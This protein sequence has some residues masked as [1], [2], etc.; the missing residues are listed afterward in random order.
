MSQAEWK[1]RRANSVED[2]WVVGNRVKQT[3]RS[4]CQ[5]K[6]KARQPR[7]AT[8]EGTNK[9]SNRKAGEEERPG[10]LSPDF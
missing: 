7:E 8:E 5:K 3:N 4:E 9:T 2:S 1:I 10:I 6:G